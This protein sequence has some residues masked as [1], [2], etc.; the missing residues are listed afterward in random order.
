MIRLVKYAKCLPVA[1][2]SFFFFKQRQGQQPREEE[3]RVNIC[4]EMKDGVYM[5]TPTVIWFGKDSLF[6]PSQLKWKNE[7]IMDTQ[8]VLSCHAMYHVNVVGLSLSFYLSASL[9]FSPHSFVCFS[10]A[11]VLFPTLT[12]WVMNTISRLSLQLILSI[13]FTWSVILKFYSTLLPH[14]IPHTLNFMVIQT[15]RTHSANK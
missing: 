7:Q 13:Y 8:M 1:L 15:P 3:H 10:L 4:D 5:K 2:I 14:L 9:S 6:P 11:L 12:V